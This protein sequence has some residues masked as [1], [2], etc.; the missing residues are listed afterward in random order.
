M[1][2]HLVAASVLA[3]SL[4]AVPAMANEAPLAAIANP[5]PILSTARIKDSDDR[6][7][8]AVQAVQLDSQGHAMSV[9]VALLNSDSTLLINADRFLYDADSNTLIAPHALNG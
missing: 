3:A 6:T 2:R 8:G 4:L 9:E 1:T 7:I 5:D